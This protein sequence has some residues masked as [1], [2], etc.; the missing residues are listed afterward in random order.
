M[1]DIPFGLQMWID[2]RA[3]RIQEI[4]KSD[5][6]IPEGVKAEWDKYV[7]A[8]NWTDPETGEPDPAPNPN[9]GNY[10]VEKLLSL[11]T[12]WGQQNGYNALLGRI[13]GELPPAGCVAIAMAQ[14][15]KYHEYPS[16]YNWDAMPNTY[17]TN[18]TAQL[19]KDI[20]SK[21]DMNYGLDGSGTNTKNK[22]PPAFNEFGYSSSVQ[23]SDYRSDIIKNE[24]NANRPVIF[25]G[26][27]MKYWAGIIPYYADGHAWVCHGYQEANINGYGYFS[28]YMNWGWY[29]THNGW[30][31]YN[32]FNNENGTYNYKVGIIFGI[33]P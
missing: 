8:P 1:N 30:Y 7:G 33:K 18:A 24:M 17:A 28:M 29:N 21:V 3:Q 6:E 23:Y 20:G 13:D 27:T 12:R 14:V 4:K 5:I 22:V 15:M 9:E 11:S 10:S 25:K 32:S 26:G 16:S 2:V 31:S 19:I